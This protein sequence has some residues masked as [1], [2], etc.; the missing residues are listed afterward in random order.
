MRKAAYDAHVDLL[1]KSCK[2][3][4]KEFTI[5]ITLFILA[6]AIY[7]ING[8]NQEIYGF[9]IVDCITYIGIFFLFIASLDLG[10]VV[11]YA[12]CVWKLNNDEKNV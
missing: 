11:Y 3:L 9:D 12:L 2:D 8:T 1:I 6:I 10:Y 7:F 4:C 5:A